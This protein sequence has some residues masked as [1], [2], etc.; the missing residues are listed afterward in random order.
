MQVLRKHI[1]TDQFVA[2]NA[3]L[4]ALIFILLYFVMKLEAMQSRGISAFFITLGLS[5]FMFYGLVVRMFLTDIVVRNFNRLIAVALAIL[6]LFTF[7]F[8]KEYISARL[9]YNPLT[10]GGL[11]VDFLCF[12]VFTSLL[13][14][15][16]TNKQADF[17]LSLTLIAANIILMNRAS[18]F[19]SILFLCWYSFSNLSRKKIILLFSTLT[20]L[21]FSLP[22]ISSINMYTRLQLGLD[23]DR[24]KLIYYGFSHLFDLH[25]DQTARIEEL[26]N[27]RSYHFFPLDIVRLYPTLWIFI[28]SFILSL[29]FLI[30][31]INSRAKRY[32]NA[33]VIFIFLYFFYFS[34]SYE[35]SSII[36]LMIVTAY[37]LHF[38]ENKSNLSENKKSSQKNVFELNSAAIHSK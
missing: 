21:A 2:V 25:S 18:S 1:S 12:G 10:K 19:V 7:I 31:L 24:F 14:L 13:T 8:H 35:L 20:L 26:Y 11:V 36:M 29:I 33:M 15:F 32:T 28:V 3:V 37:Q 34:P 22:Y 38:L 23:S 30:T 27:V 16:I 5:F 17:I 9:L 4:G 6:F